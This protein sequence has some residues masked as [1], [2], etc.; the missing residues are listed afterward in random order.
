MWQ[1]AI[2]FIC[3]YLD[4]RVHRGTWTYRI[5]LFI[6]LLIQHPIGVWLLILS[7]LWHNPGSWSNS[8][9]KKHRSWLRFL[10]T[11]C[12]KWRVFILF[13]SSFHACVSSM[14]YGLISTRSNLKKYTGYRVDIA[15]FDFFS[16]F[17]HDQDGRGGCQRGL[18]RW[19]IDAKKQVIWWLISQWFVH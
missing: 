11:E 13:W 5:P 4:V 9:H 1:V 16:F 12:S 19:Y 15:K 8:S 18:A 10:T 14:V 6:V 2:M 17:H 3:V 7:E